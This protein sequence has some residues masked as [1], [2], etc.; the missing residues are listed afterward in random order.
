MT[1]GARVEDRLRLRQTLDYLTPLEFAEQREKIS[2][3]KEG[4]TNHMN[5]HGSVCI[6]LIAPLFFGKNVGMG[7]WFLA[8]FIGVSP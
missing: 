4:I 5:E 7:K 1:S 3:K 8:W 2:N 6:W